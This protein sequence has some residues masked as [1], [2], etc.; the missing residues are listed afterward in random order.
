MEKEAFMFKKTLAMISLI[1]FTASP[2]AFASATR[3]KHVENN[4]AEFQRK[5]KARFDEYDRKFM[6][7]S[8]K[9]KRQGEEIYREQKIE[10]EKS[11]AKAASDIKRLNAKS[12]KY[13]KES[14]VKMKAETSKALDSF[15]KALERAGSKLR[16]NSAK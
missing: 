4:N 13:G 5:S 14:W 12:E 9:A 7:W 16:K 8:E 11:R 2:A 15:G 1:V 6:D 3:T 10:L